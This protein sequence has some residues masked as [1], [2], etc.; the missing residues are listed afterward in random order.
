MP[1]LPLPPWARKIQQN[2]WWQYVA[3]PLII[4]FIAALVPCLAKGIQNIETVCVWGAVNT[5]PVAVVT[6]LTSGHSTGSASFNADG[7]KKT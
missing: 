5:I 7:T 4:G 6:M 3:Q 2:P 1:D